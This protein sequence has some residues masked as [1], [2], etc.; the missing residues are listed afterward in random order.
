MDLLTRYV[1]NHSKVKIIRVGQLT[2]ISFS[3]YFSYL[4]GVGE[5]GENATEF[6]NLYSELMKTSS[7]KGHLASN[8]ALL[9]IRDLITKVLAVV[10]E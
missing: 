10:L 9:T 8:G 5:A 7:W 2:L 1:H 3:I 4:Q 6:F